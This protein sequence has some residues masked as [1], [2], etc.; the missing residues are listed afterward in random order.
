[1]YKM[2]ISLW[3]QTLASLSGAQTRYTMFCLY[4]T[5]GD[6]KVILEADTQVWDHFF[7]FLSADL[8]YRWSFEGQYLEEDDD[9]DDDGEE[10]DGEEVDG[11]AE[12]VPDGSGRHTPT[13]WPLRLVANK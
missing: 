13:D 3:K 10:V 5:V 1:M 11:E 2:P 12:E 6:D 4:V 8:R 7:D 9:D